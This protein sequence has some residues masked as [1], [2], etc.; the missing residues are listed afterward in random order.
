MPLQHRWVCFHQQNTIDK[1][2]EKEN[3]R[4]HYDKEDVWVFLIVAATVFGLI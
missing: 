1:Y 2:K 4:P 3:P